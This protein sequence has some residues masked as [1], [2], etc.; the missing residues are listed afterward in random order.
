MSLK[1]KALRGVL[2]TAIQN[3]GGQAISFIVFLVLARLLNPEDFGLVALASVFFAFM[4]VFLDQ[5]FSQAIVQRRELEPD[6]LDTAFWTN[7][8]IGGL[9][10]ITSAASAGAIAALFK[11]PLLT[12]IIGWLSLNFV[13]GALNS[14]Q[15][16]ILSR[17]LAFKT[18]AWRS[19]V[20]LL[21]GGA[22]GVAMALTGWGVWSLVGQQLTNS[23]VG[24]AVLWQVS[25]WR[26]RLRFSRRHF[27]ELF[28][29]G[30]NVVGINA[31]NFLNRRADDFLIGYFLGPVALGY[32]TVAY[33]ILLVLSQLMIGTIQKTAMPVFSKL[34]AEPERLK[35]AFY[36]AIQ[37]TSLVAF[38]VF[39]GLSALAPELVVLV[40]GEQWRPSI[41]VMQILGWIGLLYAGFYYNGPMI[42]ALGKPG[43]N[44]ALNCVQALANVVAFAIAVRW[45]IVAVAASYVLRGY[46]MA[47]LTVWVVH[48]LIRLDFKTYFRQ[49]AAPFAGAGLMVGAIALLKPALSPWLPLGAAVSVYVLAGG[50]VYSAALFVIAPDL[51]RRALDLVRSAL[52]DRRWR[53]T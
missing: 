50:L 38:P 7:V 31:L 1:Q 18:L 45:G 11:Q 48:R 20:G 43:W 3:W 17:E 42:M 19:L 4:Q 5:G 52:P 27:R 12:P 28:S 25:D 13:L 16:A 14:V 29:Y 10:T 21:A 22:T 6:H 8:L 40:F 15:T 44:L 47:P 24:V 9:L 36:S 32:Y 23:V 49:Y 30:I 39:L 34:Q 46:L 35:G 2:W 37:M 26:P 53:K 51:S 33:R 41:P